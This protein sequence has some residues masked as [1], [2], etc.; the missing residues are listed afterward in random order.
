MVM[1]SHYT[2]KRTE[3]V[4]VDQARDQSP[5]ADTSDNGNSRGEL[6]TVEME[7]GSSNTIQY[8]NDK[9]V[10]CAVCS[11]LSDRVGV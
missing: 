2:Q 8:P 10:A 6:F 9:E 3:F 7:D 11:V 4:C 1:S 5:D